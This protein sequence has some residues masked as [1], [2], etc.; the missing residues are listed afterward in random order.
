MGFPKAIKAH[1]ANNLVEA[2][3]QY[4]RALQQNLRIQCF[5]KITVLLVQLAKHEKAEQV[6]QKGLTLFPKIIT[7]RNYANLL[8]RRRPA[9]AAHYYTVHKTNL[10]R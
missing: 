2:E 6:Y 4:E 9:V 3:K 8:R 10:F 1:K 7:F 5:T